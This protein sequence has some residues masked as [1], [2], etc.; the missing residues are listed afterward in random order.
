[1]ADDGDNRD[2]L[3]DVHA[4]QMTQLENEIIGLENDV[5]IKIKEIEGKWNVQVSHIGYDDEEFTIRFEI[6]SSRTRRSRV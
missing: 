3:Y 4:S 1:M 6:G 2:E 5:T